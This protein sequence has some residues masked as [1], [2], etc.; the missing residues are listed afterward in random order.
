MRYTRHPALSSLK[1]SAAPSVAKAA[2]AAL[3]AS[4]FGSCARMEPPPGGPEDKVRPFVSAVYPAP[5][6][7]SVP[8]R[9]DARIAFSE[10]V[11]PDAA[12]GKVWISPPPPRR[13]EV[14]HKG[15][16]LL[17]RSDAP[18]DSG[19]TYVIGVAGSIKDLVGQ[20]LEGPFQLAFSTGTAFDSGRVAGRIS[21][22]AGGPAPAGTF[23]ALYPLDPAL[24]RRFGHLSFGGPS[25]LADSAPQPFREPPAYVAPVDSQGSFSVVGLRPGDYRLLAFQDQD[26]DMFPDPALEPMAAGPGV[27][28]SA[29]PVLKPS[30]ALAPMDTTPNRLSGARWVHERLVQGRSLGTLRLA[31][32]R[33]VHPVK[34]LRR[35][36]YTVKRATADGKRPSESALPI[37]VMGIGFDPDGALELLTAPL[38]PESAYV[39]LCGPVPDALGN[40]LDTSRDDASFRAVL[41]STASAATTASAPAAAPSGAPPAKDSSAV[42][43][44]KAPAYPPLVFLAPR[45]VDGR[46]ARL[47]RESLLPSRGLTAYYPRVLDDSLV[48]DLAAR[49][50]VKSDTVPVTFFLTR[51]GPHGLA[52]RLG[53]VPL[54]GQSLHIGHKAPKPPTLPGKADSLAG[55]PGTPAVKTDTGTGVPAPGPATPPGAAPADGPGGN[56]GGTPPPPPRQ[57]FTVCDSSRLGSLEFRQDPTARGALLV[58]RSLVPGLEFARYTPDRES[59]TVDSLPAGWYSVDYFRD[60]DRDTLWNPGRIKPWTPQEEFA[61]FADSVEVKPGGVSA[62]GPSGRRLSFPPAW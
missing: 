44:T 59:F 58:L 28:V 34:A 41:D 21:A 22:F 61:R 20:S 56:P 48:A 24:R 16:V 57:T 35:E 25:A 7:T 14:E 55:K 50:E 1:R 18:L 11:S 8:R 43:G 33:P 19:T 9:L 54:K 29:S 49:L 3:A 46:F 45:G 38:E 53:P 13:L 31:F 52:F 32:A 40:L 39:V 2:I 30:L 60:A 47:P 15:N 12:R 37:P 62:G 17:L 6:A 23:A 27:A 51:T 26:A 36:L 4:L 42:A 5:G 10:W